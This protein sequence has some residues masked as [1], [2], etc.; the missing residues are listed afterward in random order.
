MTEA[1]TLTMIDA[2]LGT[3]TELRSRA[4][5]EEA[6]NYRR[7]AALGEMVEVTSADIDDLL[8]AR[9]ALAHA[10]DPA[11]I[12]D[13]ARIAVAWAGYTPMSPDAATVAVLRLAREAGYSGPGIEELPGLIQDEHGCWLLDE[14][15]PMTE[16]FP[17]RFGCNAQW[18]GVAT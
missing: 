1:M 5:E 16:D 4:S 2:Q 3:L 9:A 14:D 18:L 12:E 10:E 17:V 11:T 13:R 8:M 7:M 6:E 15:D